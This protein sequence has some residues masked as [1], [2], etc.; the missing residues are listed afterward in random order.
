MKMDSLLAAQK[1]VTT[2]LLRFD[3]EFFGLLYRDING[4]PKDLATQVFEHGRSISI[5]GVRG[6]GK[7]TL[8]QA[9]LWH[10][11]QTSSKKF[12]PVIVEVVGANNVSDQSSLA[13]KFYRAV[14][15]G[16]I[17]AGSLEN[18]HSKIKSA[19]S[20]HVPW[21]A[22]SA[23]SAL[24]FIFP[25]IAIGSRATQRAVGSLLDKLGIKE[26][27]ESSL[28][29]NKNIEPKIAVD[30]IVERL[31]DSDIL[32]VFV[33]DE[34]DKVPNDTMLSEFF[35]GN[36]GWFQG[37]RTIISLSH[38]FGQSVEKKI[39]ES[40]GRF[41]Q[42]QKIEGPTSAEQ[43]KN[44]LYAR[45]LLGISNIEPNESRAMQIVQSIFPDEVVEQIVNRYVPNTY[46]M[47][48][49]AYR[50]IQ[51]ARLRKATQLALNDL[52]KFES[53]KT[54]E[55]TGIE[56]KILDILSK[57]AASP[58]ELIAKT[59]KNRGTITKSIKSLYSDDL[60]EKTG[61]GKNVQY[62]IT[63]KGEAARTLSQK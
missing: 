6:I 50:A 17:S 63:Q 16:L 26:S 36:Q 41:S 40:L 24:G 2:W 14:L 57:N 7:T 18:K 37:K 60:I 32:P 42:A 8:M 61:K 43:F 3:D 55:P 59:K 15:S 10:G 39:I 1:Y 49:H 29:I 4:T 45:L 31:A 34:L 12:L 22:A 19:V 38:T 47:L 44:V 21:M 11:L 54:R 30:F 48:E 53:T 13:D 52:E 9:V 58:K 23:V 25:P 35:D 62:S 46:L 28:L 27:G 56:L 5:Y 33:I 20:A 51:K